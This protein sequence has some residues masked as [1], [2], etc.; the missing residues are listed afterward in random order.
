[1]LHAGRANG[2]GEWLGRAGHLPGR[3]CHWSHRSGE[4]ARLRWDCTVVLLSGTRR[5]VPRSR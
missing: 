2:A 4:M 3:S 5:P 1:V